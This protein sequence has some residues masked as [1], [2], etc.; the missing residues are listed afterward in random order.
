MT[1][2]KLKTS[3]V[4]KTRQSGAGISSVHKSHCETNELFTKLACCYLQMNRKKNGNSNIITPM[5]RQSLSDLKYKKKVIC[6]S[7]K[8]DILTVASGY[9]KQIIGDGL[10][11]T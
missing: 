9:W 7:S 6:S 5:Y 11:L 1:C 10:Q 2:S 8:G 4:R 3:R